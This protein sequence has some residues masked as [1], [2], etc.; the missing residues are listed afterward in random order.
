MASFTVEIQRKFF[1]ITVHIYRDA[2]P[3]LFIFVSFS[4]LIPVN[5]RNSVLLHRVWFG[6]QKYYCVFRLFKMY[7]YCQ[8][9]LTDKCKQEEMKVETV[10]PPYPA[11][12]FL[13]NNPS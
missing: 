9:W 6:L 2:S 5:P 12:F 7:T 4:A 11:Y 1:E 10:N 13:E 3:T 8:E